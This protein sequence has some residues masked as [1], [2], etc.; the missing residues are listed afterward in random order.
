MPV[1]PSALTLGSLSPPMVAMLAVVV[2]GY[3]VRARTLASEGRPV[4]RWRRVCFAASAAL[5]LVEP[6][7]PIGAGADDSFTSHMLEH[8]LIGDFA[9]LL[10]VLGI[11]GPLIAPLLRLDLIAKLRVLAHPLVALP[12]WLVNLYIWHLPVMM[13]GAIDHDAIHVFQH[14]LFFGLGF[15]MWM[16]LFGPLPRPA[17]FGN[18]AQLFYIVVVRLAGVLL[19]NFFIFSGRVYYDNYAGADNM[20]GMSAL[21]DQST[22]GAVMMAEGT[23]VTFA[24]LAWLFVKAAR[25]SDESQALVDLAARHGVELSPERSARA[26]ASGAGGR[27][28]E[29]IL[30]EA[31]VAERRAERT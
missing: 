9:A 23:I 26:V 5:L 4:P 6:L 3:V 18:V 13:E 29:R 2:A 27:L 31:G 20:W 19:G 21:A 17:W 8:L 28:R 12:L 7:S 1:P 15:N 30:R 10:M 16:P 14:M 25:E 24:L 11:T 22:A